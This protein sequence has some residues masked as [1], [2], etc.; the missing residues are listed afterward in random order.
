MRGKNKKGW[1]TAGFNDGDWK[2]AVV[3]TT[4]ATQVIATYNEPVMAQERLKPVHIQRTPKGE[5]VVDFGQNMVG[6]VQLKVRGKKGDSIT[7]SHA[8]V[9]DKAR[10]LL[11]GQP[12]R[13]QSSKTLLS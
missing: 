2:R 11:H 9:L 10:Q 12:A 4:P 13:R 5:L 3:K 1:A 6:F 8:E 7:L